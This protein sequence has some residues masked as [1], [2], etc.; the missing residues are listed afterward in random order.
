MYCMKSIDTERV[1]LLS[2]SIAVVALFIS[3]AAWAHDPIFGLGP[4]VLYKGGV[5]VAPQL[6]LEKNSDEQETELG[7]ELVYGVTGDW[8]AG[9]EIPYAWKKEGS[10]NVSGTGV[11]T[12][13]R[14]TATGVTTAL[15]PRKAPTRSP[16]VTQ[17]IL[18]HTKSKVDQ[19][20]VLRRFIS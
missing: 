5:E 10:K 14:S 6:H 7:L 20:F 1:M 4:H 15:V 3:G 11:L 12:C 13:L 19:L 16:N 8:A 2:T 9:L 17:A 18:N